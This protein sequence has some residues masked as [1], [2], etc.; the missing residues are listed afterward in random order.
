VRESVQFYRDNLLG[1]AFLAGH[2]P[3]EFIFCRNL[4]IYF[5][6]ATQ[7]RALEKL[8]QLLTP[9]GVLFVGPAE[10]PLATQNGFVNANL[11]M[12]F[13]SRKTAAKPRHL[14]AGS[15]ER[16]AGSSPPQPCSLLPAPCCSAPCSAPKDGLDTARQLAD[17]GHLEEAATVCQAHLCNQGPSAQAYYLLGLVRDSRGDPKAI[18]YYRKALYLDPDH[19]ETLLQMSLL[20]EKAGDVAGAGIFKRRA[21]RAQ[22]VARSG[23]RLGEQKAS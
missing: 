12:A 19:H 18:E 2:R 5:D 21:Q 23:L 11:R 22:P 4:L 8:H 15:R 20:L 14:V 1:E 6:C 7:E 9:E 3:Y 13:A 10:L 16:G 17:A